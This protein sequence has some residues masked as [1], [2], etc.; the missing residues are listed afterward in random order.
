MHETE[1]PLTAHRDNAKAEADEQTAATAFHEAHPHVR[2]LRVKTHLIVT[3]AALVLA[4]IAAAIYWPRHSGQQVAAEHT[5]KATTPSI[6]ADV[7]LA[8]EGELQQLTIEPVSLRSISVERETTGKVAFN[9]DRMTPVFTPYAGRVIEVLANKGAVV[10]AGEPLLI[11]EAPEL[12]AVQNEFH[13]ARADVDKSK[14]ALDFAQKAAERAR[15][16]HER[17]ALATKDLQQAETELLRAQEELRRDQAA[18]NVIENKLALFGK[19][20]AE[21]AQLANQTGGSLDRR[22]VIRA[23]LNGTVVERKVGPGEYIKPDLP[24]PLFMLSDLST[25]WVQADV[26]ESYLSSIRVGS[27]VQISTAAYPERAFPARVSFINPTVDAETHTVR[28]RCVV[29]N[30]GGALKPEMFAKIKIGAATPTPVPAVPTGAL[31]TLNN[32]NYV[33]VEETH[34]R[35]RRRAVKALRE[36]NGFTLLAA[37]LTPNERV[38]TKGVLLL[39][40]GAGKTEE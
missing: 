6:P 1:T 38:V 16:L 24:D 29:S 12:V 32:D 19:T 27:P 39:N 3:A 15:A 21:I 40:H 28:V 33:M 37:G 26:N 22:V 35:F 14:I 25:L 17:E 18:V 2:H 10:K 36:E 13:A 34:G 11:V 4:I 31:F 30:N 8:D 9:E 23:P 5:A 7:A 20:P